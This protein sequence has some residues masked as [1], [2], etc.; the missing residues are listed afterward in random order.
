MYNLLDT[1]VIKHQWVYLVYFLS[2]KM[3]S[4]GK[5]PVEEPPDD[6]TQQPSSMVLQSANVPVVQ[7]TPSI[8]LNLIIKVKLFP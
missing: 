8:E 3:D 7:Q 1:L 5:L 2:L 4:L 6:D